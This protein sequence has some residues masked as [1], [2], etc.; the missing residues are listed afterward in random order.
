M[1]HST[2]GSLQDSSIESII[3]TNNPH[4]SSTQII[5]TKFTR[6]IPWPNKT[7][8]RQSI[9]RRAHLWK[10]CIK[11]MI[12]SRNDPS[13]DVQC[14]LSKEGGSWTHKAQQ[15]AWIQIFNKNASQEYVS[16][17]CCQEIEKKTR[18][19]PEYE[20]NI[21]SLYKRERTLRTRHALY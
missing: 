19:E 1:T 16:R 15:R 12:Q 10:H 21:S 17:I 2:N 18:P 4:K 20:R 9:Q 5:H 8:H 6:I 13:N 3:H 14:K 11:P 7:W